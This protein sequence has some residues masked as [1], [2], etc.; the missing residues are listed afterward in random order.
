MKT[1][2]MKFGMMV[3]AVAALSVGTVSCKK[4]GCTDPNAPNYDAEAQ[5]DDGS[6]EDPVTGTTE[7]EVI[8]SG[9][10]TS[11]TTWTANNVYVLINK[12]VVDNGATLTIEPFQ[13]SWLVSKEMTVLIST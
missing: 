3:L 5:K 4:K 1:K 13:T 7:N 12:V 9:A 10:I 8:V 11:N 2:T 6:C